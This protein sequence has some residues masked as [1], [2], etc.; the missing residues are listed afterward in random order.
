MWVAA[1][2]I[3]GMDDFAQRELH[4]LKQAVCHGVPRIVSFIGDVECA[5]DH[6]FIVLE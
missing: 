1:K 2:E 3:V 6:H 4:A 5:S